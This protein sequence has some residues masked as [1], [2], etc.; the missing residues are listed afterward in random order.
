MLTTLMQNIKIFRVMFCY[1]KIAEFIALMRL[2][3]F[4]AS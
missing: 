1:I 3:F 2:F 4:F